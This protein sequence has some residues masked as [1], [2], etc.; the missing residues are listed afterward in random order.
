MRICTDGEGPWRDNR[1]AVA[2]SFLTAGSDPTGNMTLSGP[3][4]A[5]CPSDAMHSLHL[6]SRLIV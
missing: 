5:A 2:T 3:D 6:A 4:R 1:A